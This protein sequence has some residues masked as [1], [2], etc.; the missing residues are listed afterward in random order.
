[1]YSIYPKKIKKMEIPSISIK[2][3]KVY[4]YPK[5]PKTGQVVGGIRGLQ[6][7]PTKA[8]ASVVSISDELTHGS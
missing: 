6:L 3:P 2:I 8:A 4:S 1:V 5:N 7:S